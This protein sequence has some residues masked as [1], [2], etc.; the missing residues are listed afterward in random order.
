MEIPSTREEAQRC[1]S[2]FYFTGKPCKHGHIDKRYTN[3]SI[4]YQCKRSQN[5]RDYSKHT[6]RVKSTNDISR[7]KNW[8]RV[9][10]S[11]RNWSSKNREKSNAIKKAYKVR[12]REKYLK[13][14]RDR[15]REKRW[16][17][18]F[19]L[20]KNF[21]KAMWANLKGRKGYNHWEIL[22]DYTFNDLKIHLER[23]FSDGMTWENYG[24]YWHVDHI[25]PLSKCESFEESWKLS[26]LQ[27]LKAFENLSKGNKYEDS[28]RE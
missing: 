1:S 11:S 2:V 25:K 27:P 16:D 5:K 4:C 26:N 23:Q 9:L 28:S 20:N 10:Q 7:K 18:F 17:P 24:S 3:T 21:S 15:Q 14:E 13:N 12:N 8:K 19:R 6:E 22:V